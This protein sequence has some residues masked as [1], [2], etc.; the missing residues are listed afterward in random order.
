MKNY[1]YYFIGIAG[2]FILLTSEVEY[3]TG[4]PGGK[5][6]S[7]GDGGATC[8]DCHGGTATFMEGW[9]TSDIP[10]DG[11]MPGETYTITATG[12]HNGVV[13][14]GFEMTSE[15]A[16][17]I[18]VGTI[19]NTNPTET[20]LVN[21]NKSI[22]HTSNGIIPS[23][24]SKT[25]SFDWVAPA[26]GTGEVTFYGAFNAANGNGNNTGDVIYRSSYAAPEAST[27]INGV[28]VSLTGMN[29]HVGQ[30]FEAR[31]IDKSNRMEVDRLA[32]D[33][34]TNADFDITFENIIEGHSYWVDFYADLNDNGYYD[35]IPTDHAWRLSF[36]NAMNGDMKTFV[37]NTSFSEI[38]WMHMYELEFSGMTPHIGQKLE[39]R[40][41]NEADMKEAGRFTIEAIAGADFTVKLPFLN[42]GNN[43]NVDFYADLNGNGVYDAPP[44][45]HAWRIELMDV[46]GDEDDNFSHNTNFTDIG[47]DY[48]CTLNAMGMGP[49]LGQL[50]EMRAMNMSTL[51]EAGRIRLDSI[52][53]ADF[54]AIATGLEL[55]ED[56]YIDFYADFNGNGVYDPPPADHA[57]RIELNDVTGDSEL[58]FTHNTSFTDIEWPVT[59][60]NKYDFE[61]MINVYPNPV[62]NSFSLNY[63]GGVADIKMMQLFSGTGHLVSTLESIN[64]TGIT[65]IG[66]NGLP[67]GVYFLMIKLEN[68][69]T[70]TKRIVKL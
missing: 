10:A 66:M 1:F 49:H 35:G 23:G 47:W 54:A 11:Y 29:P 19:M 51:E 57:W 53:L 14:F 36:N 4:S 41:V 24:N 25:W 18:K 58:D 34:I 20:Q 46:E 69:K 28:T 67:S 8:T 50:F 63:S 70:L 42:S 5:T 62:Q 17:A 31:L 7:P 65:K 16:S 44:A 27:L 9:I 33:P 22:T 12:T 21:G 40:L 43:Y 2:M 38:H 6:G 60:I 68:D 3:H 13:R 48:R 30:L 45:D 55:G 15:D 39:I 52:V 56:Y 26:E 61:D 59:G 37:H 64:G 32:I